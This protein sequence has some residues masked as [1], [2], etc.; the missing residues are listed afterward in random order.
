MLNSK[1][2]GKY[3]E[4][5]D[6]SFCHIGS[7][8]TEHYNAKRFLKLDISILKIVVVETAPIPTQEFIWSEGLFS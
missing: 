1:G 4:S 5:I 7:N 8:L 6:Y 3:V 2:P